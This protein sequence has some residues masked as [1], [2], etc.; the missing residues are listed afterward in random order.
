MAVTIEQFVENLI[1]SGLFSAGELAAFRRSLPAERQPK[2]PQALAGE[3]IRAGKL[4]KY[5][6]G[7][8]Y[9]GK[10]KGL[11]LGDYVVLDEIGHGGMGQVYR[12]RHRTMERIVALK[13][14]AHKA[15]RSPHAVERFRR[16]VKAAA[17]LA[18]PNIVTAHDA[19]E[20]DGIHYL[21]TEYVDGHDLARV[22]VERGPLPAD[23]A[24][25]CTLQAARGLE[26]AHRH[27]VVH[28]D[29][30]P[31]NLLLDREGVVRILDMGLARLDEPAG[32]TDPTAAEPLTESGR[33]MGTY[34]YMAPEQAEDAHAADH[35][36]DVYSLGCTLYRII[37]GR[38]PYK[39]ETP[40][41]I[42]LSHRDDPIPSLRAA[43]D[44]VPPALD[45]ACGKMMAKRPEDRFGSMAEVIGDLELCL[46]RVPPP[47][48][49]GATESSS[50]SDS[51]L[52]AFLQSM[53]AQRT[54][55]KPKTGTP[56][57]E[58][59]L[60]EPAMEE[61]HASAAKPRAKP[62]VTRWSSTT[63]ALVGLGAGGAAVLIAVALLT[64][65][66]R[67]GSGPETPSREDDSRPG[68][69]AAPSKDAPGGDPK[70]Q[71]PK[72]IWQTA[73]AT[74][75]AE[76]G[77]LILQGRFGEAEAVFEELLNRFDDRELISQVN[78]AL[79]DIQ[80]QARTAYD[81]I[82]AQAKKLLDDGQFADA[83]A[84][85]KPVLDQ[86]GIAATTE[87]AKKL[88]TQIDEAE[89]EAEAAA[90]AAK[91]EA[92]RKAAI[93]RLRE[94][95][96]LYA[97]KVGP[98]EEL[99]ATWDF[100]GALA[101]L[102]QVEFEQEDRNNR[103]AAR[104]EELG[105]L[106]GLKERII[107]A[108]N[109][110]DPPFQKQALGI[111][112]LGGKVTG[113]DENGITAK[114]FNGKTESL[115][116]ADV[117]AKASPKL[118]ALAIDPKSGDDH[119]A[120]GLLAL[121][122]GDVATAEAHFHRAG[123]LGA[124]IDPYLAKLAATAFAQALALL[125]SEQFPEAVAA[126]TEI[127]NK[128]AALPWFTSH[129]EPFAAAVAQARAGAYEAEA[130]AL[131]AE[132]KKLFEADQPFDLKPLVEKLESDYATSR[133]LTVADRKPSIADM[134]AATANLGERLTVAQNEKAD[135]RTIQAAIDAVT[136]PNSMVEVVDE[137]VYKETLHISSTGMRLL[138]RRKGRAMI[139]GGF[140]SEPCV[141]VGA[142]SVT[143]DGLL[144]NN[145]EIAVRIDSQ[146][147][148]IR[149]C[150]IVH[151]IT[152]PFSFSAGAKVDV[153]HSLL[154][155]CGRFSG[156]LRES[157]VCG[158]LKCTGAEIVDS[159]ILNDVNTLALFSLDVTNSLVTGRI[160]G[161]GRKRIRECTVFGS[162][163]GAEP[164]YGGLFL[165]NSICG[166]VHFLQE[167]ADTVGSC[168]LFSQ[169]QPLTGAEATNWFSAPPQFRDPAN[170]DYR[171][172]PT[173]PCI[174]KALDGGDIG[175]R[176]TP[177]M[178]EMCK[179]ALELR[180]KGIIKF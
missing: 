171:L 59:L 118:I 176:F 99:T 56:A 164:G 168:N 55:G 71:P 69:S 7:R 133:A 5:Q 31:A 126:L 43:R 58:T 146:K 158:L 42:L 80:K 33:V 132:A 91:Q 102:E 112:G 157:V 25:D 107:D 18:H 116:W 170:L 10:T 163:G 166:S 44:D 165:R 29:V 53:S 148:T 82:E 48:P 20:H 152:T 111:G 145:A 110:A 114:L 134:T 106:I 136:T 180:A 1:R 26:Y 93:E 94:E 131:Y 113:A 129:Q 75:D 119:L 128:H 81:E 179:I 66:P 85:L 67:G 127:E 21:V 64:M 17:R 169:S 76:A 90:M 156:R 36:A 109:A 60:D 161:N 121:A 117:G 125:E 137:A 173:S 16:E 100:R 155:S 50:S 149:N 11:V 52:K 88:L 147:C 12:A 115:A 3:L 97:E 54:G 74:A 38:R 6:A 159:L 39:G 30:K 160:Y 123:T 139:D 51:A 15:L 177:E 143:I 27:G 167:G 19:G 87:A 45:A 13:V 57:E 142:G 84:A 61:T 79:G 172:M 178:I 151:R 4:T 144:F 101:A 9:R 162:V 124:D 22:L 153:E 14:L 140:G 108:I 89:Q 150:V 78:D 138:A 135:F 35:R 175:C 130:E 98:A 47:P 174:G 46:A 122:S 70:K 73:W 2:D 40:V 37:S 92:T 77:S 68:A 23:V 141:T 96:R 65:L 63:R 154:G 104:R 86:H 62:V 34:D 95:E 103:V 24:V 83:R 41:Q 120:A 8:V 105:L 49:D 32:P 72:P 28:R